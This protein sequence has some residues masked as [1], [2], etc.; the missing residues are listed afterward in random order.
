M[1]FISFTSC[2][3][4]TDETKDR[5]YEKMAGQLFLDGKRDRAVGFLDSVYASGHV[6]PL[7]LYITYALKS[8]YFRALGDQQRGLE[9]ADSAIAILR[10]HKLE[11]KYEH[12]YAHALLEKGH[13][14][15]ELAKYDSAY[16]AYMN[17]YSFVYATGNTCYLHEFDH[18]MGLMLFR[19]YRI[20]EARTFF[21]RSFKEAEACTGD[22]KPYYR[23]QELLSNIGLT[24]PND[25]SIFYY[26]SCLS[27]IEKN[28]EHFPTREMVNEA[29]GVCYLNKVNACQLLGKFELAEQTVYKALDV[30]QAMD[31]KKKYRP[32]VI[33]CRMALAMLYYY[34]K[35]S[36]KLRGEWN[37]IEPLLDTT[38]ELPLRLAAGQ[39]KYAAYEMEKDYK[40]AYEAYG[41][42]V[43][44]SD[45]AK[46]GTFKAE[47]GGVLQ[48]M[49]AKEQE[50]KIGLL[51]RD[52]KLQRTYLWISIALSA[53]AAVIILMVYSSYKRTK[54]TNKL[55]ND[56][57]QALE[58]SNSA[59]EESNSALDRSNR[60]K[61][62]IL[63]VVAHDLRSPVS[64]VAYLADSVIEDGE[65]S[66]VDPVS[67][68]KMIKDSSLN[69]LQLI[70]ELSVF[71]RDEQEGIR[72]ERTDM[73]ALVSAAADLQVQKAAEKEVRLELVA[74]QG[75]VMA[76]VDKNK[77]TRVVSNLID[78]AI[79]FSNTG[80]AVR[81]TVRT[82]HGGVVCEVEDNGIGIPPHLLPE[83]F[84]M[85]TPSGRKGTKGE[86]SFGL[87]L[88]IC[89]QI[90]EAHG[91]GIWV[92]S[93]EGKGSRFYIQLPGA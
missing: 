93:T 67:A 10:K 33:R 4:R 18:G 28:A 58:K 66:T 85:F 62:K 27:F 17:G 75:P 70:N 41:A 82:Q 20:D 69:S 86:K 91:G 48:E 63:N 50:Y 79:K 54:R 52:A 35:D 43:A 31:D 40:N 12:E 90:A 42:Y 23:M 22:D 61:N 36:K 34:E 7:G 15:T 56:Q 64:A 53:L 57:K 73:T 74:P 55:I 14:Y 51:T 59:L 76:N 60:E 45:S 37:A 29:K 83:L 38:I 6:S 78:N 1:A 5:E 92:E 84:D 9:Y 88:S 72:P 49:K 46:S 21:E 77:M 44:F 3:E 71:A 25:T 24:H 32:H 26:D 87:G 30:Y 80:S 11:H 8:Q 68:L 16:D 13:I 81:V 39:L 47:Q 19:Q 89:R 2:R 65:D